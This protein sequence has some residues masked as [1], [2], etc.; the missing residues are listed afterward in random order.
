MIA[1][2][3]VALLARASAEILWS[4]ENGAAGRHIEALQA[5]RKRE[6][7]NVMRREGAGR[8]HR[9]LSAVEDDSK[10]S[11]LLRRREVEGRTRYEFWKEVKRGKVCSNTGTSNYEIFTTTHEAASLH[12]CMDHCE[13]TFWCKMLSYHG[14][15][16]AMTDQN[17][18]VVVGGTCVEVNG[19]NSG[20]TN[21]TDSDWVM[22]NY[23]FWPEVSGMAG[24][25]CDTSQATQHESSSN[26]VTLEDCMDKCT[27]KDWC[28]TVSWEK[29]CDDANA[30][31]RSQKWCHLVDS[32]VAAADDA[33]S[34][35]FEVF[36]KNAP[37]VQGATNNQ[38]QWN[39]AGADR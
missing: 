16:N 13:T 15:H 2:L 19:Q 3:V 24:K 18:C 31:C 25:H 6:L 22:M 5:S 35:G 12:D 10:K 33:N 37:V 38:D 9:L 39:A 29:L 11:R 20:I 26:V 36:N 21:A 30:N 32:C 23:S 8:H 1:T 7:S 14:D 28:A 17:V 34:A 27:E 4:R